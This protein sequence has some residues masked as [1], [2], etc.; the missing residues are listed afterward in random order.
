MQASVTRGETIIGNFVCLRPDGTR[1]Q[2]DTRVSPVRGHA[3]TI[4]RY[5]AVIRDVT[6]EVQLEEQLR[7]AQRME[8][9]ATLSGGIAHDFNN[10]LAAIITNTEL[11][12]DDVPAD[13][14]MQAHLKVVLQAG[15]RGKNLVRQIKTIGQQSADERYPVRVEQVVEECLLLLRAS[16]PATI[17]IR[18]HI[19]PKLGMAMADPNQL[20]QVI[21]NLCANAAEA[22]QQGGGVLEIRLEPFY[23]IAP[24]MQDYPGLTTGHYLCL[25]VKD[26]GHGMERAVM[27][28]IFDPF[29][30]TKGQ[31]KGTGLGLSVA[32]SIIKN[33]GGL[34]TAESTPGEGTTFKVF[35][36]RLEKTTRPPVEKRYSLPVRG[37]SECILLVDDEEDLVFAGQK[38]LERLG[39]EV[40]TVTD[41]RKAFKLFTEQPDRFDLI[42]T[43]QTMPYMTGEMLAREIL[44]IRSDLPIILCSGRGPSADS[45]NYERKAREIGIREVV[46]KPYERDEMT[47]AIRRVLD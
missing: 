15:L 7:T 29:F 18:K 19:A 1:F 4:V 36:P 43:D 40:V 11:T 6:H 27:E 16:L 13:S 37:G 3:D 24:Y 32:H 41:G 22:M 33:H 8:A 46:S 14:P 12:M 38:M 25:V 17:E 5:V 26:T 39:Y 9:I 23:H 45:E 42:I 30:T 21:L 28:R 31:G 2:I 44:N 47:Q 10:I 34:I 35:L 20:H